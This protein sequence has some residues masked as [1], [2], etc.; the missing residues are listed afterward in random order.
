VQ[1]VSTHSSGGGGGGFGDDGGEF[2]G[3]DD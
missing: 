1:P 3:G 2:E